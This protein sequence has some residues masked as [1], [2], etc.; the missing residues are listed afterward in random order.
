VIQQAINQSINYEYAN[1][2]SGI[3]KPDLNYEPHLSVD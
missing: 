2:T 3:L 1:L